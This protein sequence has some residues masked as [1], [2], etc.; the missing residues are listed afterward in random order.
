MLLSVAQL[1]S[2]AQQAKIVGDDEKRYTIEVPSTWTRT[3]SNSLFVNVIFYNDTA[4]KDEHLYIIYSKNTS[5]LKTAYNGNKKSQ[6]ELKNFKL[7]KE[8]DGFINE[9]PC[10]WMEYTFTSD[11]GSTFKGKQYTIKKGPY[12]FTVQFLLSDS[13]YDSKKDNFEKIISS[14][15]LK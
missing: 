13:T 9:E 12:G 6:S 11:N 1:N 10:K 5:N 8:G 14:F 3:V 2:Y 4:Q 15:K 7:I